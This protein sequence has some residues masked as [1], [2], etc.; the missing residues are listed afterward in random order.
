MG[1]PLAYNTLLS[2]EKIKRREQNGVDSVKEMT[3]ELWGLLG[4][5]KVG[6]GGGTRKKEEMVLQESV[7]WP[8]F[9]ST[10]LH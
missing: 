8:K 4:H 2:D 6:G 10:E 3:V 9:N 7:V 1:E 5:E